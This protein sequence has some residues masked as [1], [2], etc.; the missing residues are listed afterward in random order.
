MLSVRGELPCRSHNTVL[1]LL[2]RVESAFGKIQMGLKLAG[3]THH[4]SLAILE[5]KCLDMFFFNILKTQ[6]TELC[7]SRRSS[8]SHK[9]HKKFRGFECGSLTPSER[10]A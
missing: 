3:N 2:R 7:D 4:E 1:A 6:E 10:S 5:E 8:K 9:S